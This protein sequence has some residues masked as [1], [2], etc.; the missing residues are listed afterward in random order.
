MNPDSFQGGFRELKVWQEAREFRKEISTVIKKFPDY[1]KYKLT[2]QLMRSSR[3]ITANISEGYGRFHYQENIQFCRQS[4]GSLMESLDHL[5]CALDE[6]YIN[7]STFD[8][9][10]RHYTRIAKMLN[11]YIAYLKKRKETD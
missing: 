7:Q 3:S 2:D 11:G 10:E 4:R 1:E 6:G 8:Q 9:L 5:V